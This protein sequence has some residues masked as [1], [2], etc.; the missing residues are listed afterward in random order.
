MLV[1]LVRSVIIYVWIT[2]S[3]RLMGKRQIGQLQVSELVVTI[4]ISELAALPM[5]EEGTPILR[6]LLPI[7]LLSAFELLSSSLP[8]LFPNL[9]KIIDGTPSFLFNNGKINRTEMR[10]QRVTM[11]DICE[12]MRSQG[13]TGADQLASVVL[14]TNGRLSVIPKAE[15][16][17]ATAGQVMQHVQAQCGV[18]VIVILDG[19]FHEGGLKFYGHDRAWADAQLRKEGVSLKEVFFMTV[20]QDGKILTV[21][22]KDTQ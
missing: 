11:V 22:K 13:Y 2:L 17:P 14:E 3:V 16:A 4:I 1:L 12:A 19:T 8:V 15:Y 6:A 20:D 21:L 5:I 18:P 9:S 7:A 10:R